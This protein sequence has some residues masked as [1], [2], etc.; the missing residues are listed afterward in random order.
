MLILKRFEGR[1]K[2]KPEIM[3]DLWHLEKVIK[4]GDLVSGHSDRKFTTES[5]KS[6]R[7]HV[8]ITLQVEKVE[9]HKPSGA[10]KVLGII[11]AGSPEEYV[12]LKA[13]H[14]LE[15]GVFDVVDI[16][17][18]WK[19]YELDRLKEAEKGSRR[20]KLFILVM[21]DREAEFFVIREFGIDSLGK[22][23][24]LSRGK[25]I[26]ESN[27]AIKTYYGAVLDLISKKEGKIVVAGPGF[28]KDNFYDY[29][30]DKDQK[31]AKKMTVESTGN[32][33]GQ[34]VYEL[35]TKGTLD[36]I[37]R[38]SRFAEETKAVERFIAEVSRKNSKAT[39]GL[40]NVER[41]LDMKAVDE[42]L[43]LDSLLLDKRELIEHI[44]DKAEKGK[45][46]IMIVS[47]ENEVSQKLKGFTGVAALLRFSIE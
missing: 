33:G 27:D 4:P 21:D 13:H 40:D 1:I 35:L 20:E 28:E 11:V 3:E 25:Y 26:G 6:E 23:G 9:F 43:V 2:V 46:R 39:Y 44:L 15:I 18:E 16:E 17:K 37:L 42:L 36:K 29:V 8:K 22:I 31:L 14:S 10:L 30:K 34:G 38:D 41:A 19:K 24:C 47:H 32:T 5:G 45:A 7:V 12:K